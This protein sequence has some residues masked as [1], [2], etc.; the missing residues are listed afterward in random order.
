MR[1]QVTL[2]PLLASLTQC[3]APSLY[4]VQATPSHPQAF[5]CAVHSAYSGPAFN[6][7]SSP[8]RLNPKTLLRTSLSLCPAFFSEYCGPGSASHTGAEAGT[9]CPYLL[10][11]FSWAASTLGVWQPL[12]VG[13]GGRHGQKSHTAAQPTVMAE[14]VWEHLF[15]FAER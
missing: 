5:A 10:I 3:P 13:P 12:A 1:P 9:T 2:W 6:W 11:F 14:T 15:L 7:L 4:S 8:S